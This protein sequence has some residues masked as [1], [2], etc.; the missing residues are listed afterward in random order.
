MG[1]LSG[2]CLMKGVLWVC[3]IWIIS[4]SWLPF[5]AV[6]LK[7]YPCQVPVT[8]L[9]RYH[10]RA[11]TIIIPCLG[12][13]LLCQVIICSCRWSQFIHS[14]AR[15][16][17]NEVTTRDCDALPDY[18]HPQLQLARRSS[19]RNNCLLAS[20]SHRHRCGQGRWL[21]TVGSTKRSAWISIKLAGNF[22]RSDFNE[23]LNSQL[24]HYTSLR[25]LSVLPY[26]PHRVCA[27]R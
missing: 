2:V 3:F 11:I 19:G 8:S 5:S 10:S 22:I 1:F 24:S 15:N 26:P 16:R 23:P 17:N 21:V 18:H 13:C 14:L 9:F 27:M 6:W 20:L 7:W 25:Y 4:I 12:C